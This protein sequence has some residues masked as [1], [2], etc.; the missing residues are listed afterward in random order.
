MLD[1][2][3]ILI[4]TAAELTASDID[5]ITMT[6]S[7]ENLLTVWLGSEITTDIPCNLQIPAEEVTDEYIE[8]ATETI[9][10]KMHSSGI[11]F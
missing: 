10:D 6:S 9:K 7:P 8:A 11:I 1:A 4:V 2:G 5:I 3:L